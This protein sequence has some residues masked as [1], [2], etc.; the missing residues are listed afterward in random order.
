MSTT[1]ADAR[2]LE[3][4]EELDRVLQ[5]FPAVLEE[6]RRSYEEIRR[7]AERV[8]NE[9]C[10]ANAALASKVRELDGLRSH[11]EAVL[12]CLPSGVVVRDARGRIVSANRAA[13][14]LLGERAEDLRGRDE[15]PAL[16]GARAD[17]EPREVRAG[18][19]QRR[20][21]ASLYSDVRLGDG[22]LDGSVEILD[23][24]TERT[25]LTE[26]LHAAD[27]MAA[28]GTMAAGI[29]HEIRNPLNA[30]EGFASLLRR[31]AGLDERSRR[32]ASLIVE[33]VVE[34][35]AIIENM[36]SFG[37]PERLRVE[38]IDGAELLESA[39]RLAAPEP[40]RAAVRVRCDAPP[41]T[42]DRI[43]LRQAIRNLVANALEACGPEPRV[44]VEL[45][46]A[47]GEVV[48]RVADA[49][50]GIPPELRHRVLD[51]FYTTRATGTGLGL[52]LV[53]TI[54]RLHGGRVEVA[55]GP[56]SLGGAEILLRFPWS[57][58]ASDASLSNP[59]R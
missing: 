59:D 51:P 46:R 56:S 57:S 11:L 7:R 5:G 25:A 27:K 54:A 28:L 42:G 33:G 30:V 39:V 53:S 45:T 22:T 14:E 52:A 12:E 31:Q 35:D 48:V 29:A 43:K 18:G 8:E 58:A 17:G 37:S 36:L 50:P 2:A 15:H 47:G 1:P 32:W 40:A 55:S 34:A 20:V 24:R 21:L 3:S 23:D 49:G 13:L 19:G 16:Q 9:L 6:L 26:R 10:R 4:P 38:T 44:E 41:F